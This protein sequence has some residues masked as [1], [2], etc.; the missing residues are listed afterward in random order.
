MMMPI[1]IGIVKEDP[2]K[3]RRVGLSP[4]G[5]QALTG[6]GCAIFVEK[7]AGD[8][9]HFSDEE[10]RKVGAQTVYSRDEVFGRS[11]VVLRV[12]SPNEDDVRNLRPGQVLFSFV[13]MGTARPAVIN[14][15]L[16]RK[17]TTIGYELIQDDHGELPILMTMSE[18]AGQ[19]CTQIAARLLGTVNRG[20]GIIMG[21]VTGIPPATV[22]ILGAG[23]VGRSA[24]RMALASGAEVIVLDRDLR[25]L[26]EIASHTDHRVV[27]GL[28]NEFNLR[29]SVRFADVLIGAILITGEKTPHIVTEDMVREMKPGSVIIDI[30]ID[31]GGC[32]ETSRP[33]TLETPTYILHDV[34]HYCIPN[35]PA[36]VARSATYGLTNALLPYLLDMAR[37]GIESSISLNRGL[38]AGVYTHDGVC[39]N[40]AIAR[41]FELEAGTVGAVAAGSRLN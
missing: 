36:T 29:K 15:I 5:V 8:A 9:S 35:I 13:H 37:R 31:Q 16:S 25:R 21:G 26:R 41:R 18:I 33:T 22:L 1:S 14:E 40:A 23:N 28:V 34:V 2:S 12:S 32:V 27:T 20:R 19:L 39:T 6:E 11:D 38:A 7:G 3:E 10:Y 30:S 17:I 4:A 24:A